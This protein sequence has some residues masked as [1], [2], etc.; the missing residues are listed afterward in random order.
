MSKMEMTPLVLQ[1]TQGSDMGWTDSKFN[2]SLELLITL[3]QTVS[4]I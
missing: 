4:W 3:D 2:T 1:G